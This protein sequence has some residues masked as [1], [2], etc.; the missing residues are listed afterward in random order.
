MPVINV[1]LSVIL[2]SVCAKPA[3][4]VSRERKSI[5]QMDELAGDSTP[6]QL[7]NAL[8]PGPPGAPFVVR[9]QERR[10]VEE[11]HDRRLG[12]E[13]RHDVLQ[14]GLA[15]LRVERTDDPLQSRVA[16]VG[17]QP[18]LLN[19]VLL[20]VAVERIT[21]LAAVREN[22]LPDAVEP[23]V[24]ARE[25]EVL[26]ELAIEVRGVRHQRDRAE[27]PVRL[28]GRQVEPVLALFRVR[29]AE[30]GEQRIRRRIACTEHGARVVAAARQGRPEAVVA[31]I[32]LLLLVRDRRG[33]TRDRP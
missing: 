13:V 21:F 3:S 24:V 17:L 6:N 20:A 8:E 25:I 10:Q 29:R 31:V 28:Q 32:A 33:D 11:A 26:L 7:K 16:V 22:V 5:L 14:A 23:H 9:A 19:E 30:P 4:C 18:D 1:S 15:R 12:E 2:N 27:I